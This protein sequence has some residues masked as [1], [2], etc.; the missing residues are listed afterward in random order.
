MIADLSVH[1]GKRDTSLPAKTLKIVLRRFRYDFPV[2]QKSV[3]FVKGKILLTDEKEMIFQFETLP[4]EWVDSVFG[5]QKGDLLPR[6]GNISG[7]G[8]RFHIIPQWIHKTL[9]IVWKHAQTLPENDGRCK[10]DRI[11]GRNAKPSV[12]EQEP[13]FPYRF[14]RI[15]Q[16]EEE[17]IGRNVV[18]AKYKF[19]MT[20]PRKRLE[21][22]YGQCACHVQD[23]I[24]TVA[25][26]D[27]TRRWY[28]YA[29]G[30]LGQVEP[31]HLRKRRGD[32]LFSPIYV[33]AKETCK[34]AAV[35]AVCRN[36]FGTPPARIGKVPLRPATG[37]TALEKSRYER[38][39]VDFTKA[40]GT[41]WFVREVSALYAY[42][43]CDT[44]IARRS[45]V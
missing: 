29:D 10:N 7:A 5:Q 15:P 37:R 43:A 12:R 39:L 42:H 8:E 31:D 13:A 22:R 19:V 20:I 25:S 23:G 36:V 24:E 14:V 3:F 6:Q 38:F 21:D 45:V 33:S 9:K 27:G 2:F 34:D 41:K 11:Y 30:T 26:Y 32:F 28:R 44:V 16:H 1:K 35:P 17:A 40:T 18:A 4:L